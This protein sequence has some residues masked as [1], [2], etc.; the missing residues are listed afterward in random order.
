LNRLRR[1]R[2]HIEG[3]F[4]ALREIIGFILDRWERFEIGDWRSDWESL[5]RELEPTA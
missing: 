1:D 4:P 3:A 2:E 5:L